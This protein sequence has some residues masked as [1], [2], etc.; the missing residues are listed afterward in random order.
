MQKFK[1]DPYEIIAEMLLTSIV[2]FFI[3]ILAFKKGWQEAIFQAIFFALSMQLLTVAERRFNR[4]RAKSKG[5]S[6]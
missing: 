3:G 1:K 4:W 2:M 6:E 5:R